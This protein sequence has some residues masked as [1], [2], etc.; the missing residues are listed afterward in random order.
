MC[1]RN[2]D[3]RAPVTIGIVGGVTKEGKSQDTSSVDDTV[4][5]AT[6]T[7]DNMKDNSVKDDEK[8][9]KDQEVGLGSGQSDSK[10]LLSPAENLSSQGGSRSMATQPLIS[11]LGILASVFVPLLVQLLLWH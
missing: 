8:T 3:P 6:A 10:M 4:E 2:D 1:N 7:N 11:Y 5:D 9:S